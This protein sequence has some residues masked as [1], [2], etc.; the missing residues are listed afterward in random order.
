MNQSL[1]SVNQR[2]SVYPGGLDVLGPIDPAIGDPQRSDSTPDSAQRRPSSID[3]EL[4]EGQGLFVDAVCVVDFEYYYDTIIQNKTSTTPSKTRVLE[5]TGAHTSQHATVPALACPTLL[6]VSPRRDATMAA[7]GR[8]RI[9]Q[10]PPPPPATS[11]ST[12]TT[13]SSSGTT[14]TTTTTA[15]PPLTS[16]PVRIHLTGLS[17]VTASTSGS[18]WDMVGS[19]PDTY[20]V[21]ASVPGQREIERTTTVDDQHEVTLDHWL[22]GAYHADDFPIRFSIYD[23]DV[24]SDELIGVVDVTAREMA[25]GGEMRLDLRSQGDVPQTMGTLRLTI[26][27]VQ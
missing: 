6:L 21:I 7:T 12:T 27:P 9:Y 22:P 25:T 11:T 20:I 5:F 16:R 2:L 24:G 3:L 8:V 15:A 26:A 14:T 23:D 18:R 4:E 10:T 13:S 17:V 19:E 1:R